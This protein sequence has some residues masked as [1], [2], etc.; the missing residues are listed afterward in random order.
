MSV[1]ATVIVPTH[2]HGPTL[3]SSLGSALA[4]TVEDIEVLVVGDGAPDVTREIVGELSRADERVSFFDHPKG[5]R[6]GEL[7]R[8]EALAQA[9]GEIVCYLADD[10]LWFPEHVE[11]MR[12]ALNGSDF[13]GA[14][15]VHVTPAE[16]LLT[17][18]S[19]LS[20]PWF[21]ERMLAGEA[22]FVP[23]SCA[24][25]TLD[26]YRRLPEGWSP[27]PLSSP[28]DLFMWR[29][30]LSLPGLRARS[31]TLPTVV[32]L[33]ST[34]RHGWTT[35]A[36]VAELE[37]WARRV[38]DPDWSREFRAEVFDM[39]RRQAAAA[40]AAAGAVMNTRTW[41]FR[42][43]LLGAPVLGAAAKALAR[44]EAGRATEP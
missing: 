19:D 16:E 41:R 36:R 28:T 33:P 31:V 24:A 18:P 38:A 12:D 26:V 42:S 3:R 22:N 14:H 9:R 20:L 11:T 15:A 13:V 34:L 4:Q 7:Y 17:W 40:E 27:A 21:R 43:W 5:P 39:V 25:H 37:P 30:L 29:K 10:D 35:K 1:V 44:R 6:H 23:L 8:H 2:D 32:Q